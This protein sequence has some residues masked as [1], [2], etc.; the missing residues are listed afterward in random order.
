M[1]DELQDLDESRDL[2]MA[3]RN[4]T[5]GMNCKLQCPQIRR[6]N[7]SDMRYFLFW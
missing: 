3:L 2:N 6:L 5:G 1:E 4:V 7:L